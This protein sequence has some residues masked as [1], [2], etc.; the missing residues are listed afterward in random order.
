MLTKEQEEVLTYLLSVKRTLDNKISIGNNNYSLDGVS[1]QEFISRINYLEQCKMI[2]IHWFG[3]HHDNLIYGIEIQLLPPAMS[4]F[5]YKRQEKKIIEIN[6]FSFGYLS[7]F[8]PLLFS[9]L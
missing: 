8:L 1:T 3:S 4:Y 2:Q 9:Y 5:E 6:G 7:V